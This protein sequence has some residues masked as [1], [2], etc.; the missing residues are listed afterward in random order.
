[1]SDEERSEFSCIKLHITNICQSVSIHRPA[2]VFNCDVRQLSISAAAATGKC[3]QLHL[4]NGLFCL[5]P[6]LFT[7]SLLTFSPLL[8]VSLR[9][10]RLHFQSGCRKRRLNLALVFFVLISSCSAFLLIGE[11]VLFVVLGLVFFS[12]PSSVDLVTIFKL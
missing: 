7:F 8:N 11:C 6:F 1:M 4:F 5:Y 3:Y 12:V 10:D 9:I 2:A